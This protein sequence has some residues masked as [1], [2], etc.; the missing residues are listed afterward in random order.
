M[1]CDRK[2][3]ERQQKISSWVIFFVNGTLA[4]GEKEWKNGEQGG[5][6]VDINHTVVSALRSYG[7]GH[8]NYIAVVYR[9]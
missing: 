1:K 2:L 5:V 9:L 4:E 3:C 7:N 8:E 6:P